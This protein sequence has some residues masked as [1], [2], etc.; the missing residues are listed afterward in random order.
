MRNAAKSI[1]GLAA[2][3][4]GGAFSSGGLPGW[5]VDPVLHARRIIPAPPKPLTKRQKRRLRGKA[6]AVTH[7][8]KIAG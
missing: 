5:S 8:T 7:A 4:A 1:V 2:L 6:R 3:S